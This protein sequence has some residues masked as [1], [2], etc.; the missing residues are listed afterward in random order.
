M[1]WA[2]EILDISLDT[3]NRLY[4]WGWGL[5]AA[6][7]VVTM[8]GIGMLSIGT[9]TRDRDFEK[10]I[11]QLHK[12]A[13][14]SEERSKQLENDNL[15]LA[16]NLERE[17]A[18]RARIEAGVASRHVTPEQRAELIDTLKGM[19]LT[20]VLSRYNDPETA[21]Y[22]GEVA[23]A[24]IEAGTTVQA[25]SVVV[26]GDNNLTGLLVEETAD[27]RLINALVASGLATQKLQSTKNKM[28]RTGEGLN[29]IL[30]GLKPNP[31]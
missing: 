7:A 3:A 11:A 26:A 19:T 14:G 15:Q 23:S 8:L 21:T 27:P 20:V 12:S 16:T 29:A 28:L 24:L 18:A 25:G 6:G 13:A 5:S 1:A 10:N 17:R 9:R 30:V 4:S 22:A 31:F 2:S